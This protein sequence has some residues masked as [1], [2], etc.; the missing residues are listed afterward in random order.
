MKIIVDA[1]GGDFAPQAQVEG[2][3][4]AVREFGVDVILTGRKTEIMGCLEGLGE[5]GL[6]KG[7]EIV[8]ASEVVTMEDDPANV[9]RAKKDSSLVVGLHLLKDGAGD[10]FVSSGNTGALLSGATLIP[11]G[12]KGYAGRLCHL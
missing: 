5:K 2:A 10:A 9:I 8:E 11:S 7:M 6:P 1:M 12:S 3:L 4:R